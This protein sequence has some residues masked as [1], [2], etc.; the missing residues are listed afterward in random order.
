M[1]YLG[2]VALAV[3]VL[4]LAAFFYTF[5]WARRRLSEGGTEAPAGGGERLEQIERRLEWLA[6]RQEEKEEALRAELRDAH[7]A[8]SAEIE[9]LRTYAGGALRHVILRPYAVG[10]DG[11]PESAVLLLLDAGGSGA[12]LNI[13]AGRT[14]R[15]YARAVKSWQAGRLS[16]EEEQALEE[17]QRRAGR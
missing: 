1:E 12:L 5:G 3:S 8:L 7:G 17:A 15:V 10:G 11:G 6:A 4:A 13:L 16:Q 14:M 9:A 2:Y